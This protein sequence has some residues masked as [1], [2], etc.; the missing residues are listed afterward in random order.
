MMR[1]LDATQR[2]R[3]TYQ[4]AFLE[5]AERECL[6]MVLLGGQRVRLDAVKLRA[7]GVPVLRHPEVSDSLWGEPGR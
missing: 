7:F 2:V 5:R 3:C 6:P 1:A 4:S